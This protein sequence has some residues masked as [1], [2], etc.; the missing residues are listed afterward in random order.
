MGKYP[1][2]PLKAAEALLGRPEFKAALGA[3]IKQHTHGVPAGD[4]HRGMKVGFERGEGL[5]SGP[6]AREKKAVE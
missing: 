1:D 5:R 2:D 6:K 3:L 4:T